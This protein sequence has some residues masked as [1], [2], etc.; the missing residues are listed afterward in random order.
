MAA[1]FS[2]SLSRFI[3][4]SWVSTFS[5]FSAISSTLARARSRPSSRSFLFSDVRITTL[6]EYFVTNLV[7]CVFSVIAIF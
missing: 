4:A 6:A 1:G 3:A 7:V 2:P 5:Q